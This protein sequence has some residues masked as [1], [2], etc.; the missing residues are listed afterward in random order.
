MKDDLSIQ[1]K[2]DKLVTSIS[3]EPVMQFIRVGFGLSIFAIWIYAALKIYAWIIG[4]ES[5]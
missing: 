1:H 5:L 4:L 3:I 2:I